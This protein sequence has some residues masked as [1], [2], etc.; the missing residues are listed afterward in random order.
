MNKKELE[1]KLSITASS[2]NALW[3]VNR[4]DRQFNREQLDAEHNRISVLAPKVDK[5]EAEAKR[6]TEQLLDRLYEQSKLINILFNIVRTSGIVEVAET[7]ENLFQ[8]NST[9]DMLQRNPLYKINKV[10]TRV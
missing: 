2:I 10:C 9:V 3:D 6:I 8:I 1:S 4:K 7:G 5:W